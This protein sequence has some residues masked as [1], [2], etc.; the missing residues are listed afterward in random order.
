[1]VRKR[2]I[3]RLSEIAQNPAKTRA[4]SDSL[5]GVGKTPNRSTLRPLGFVDSDEHGA[6]LERSGNKDSLLVWY[7]HTA[8]LLRD[9]G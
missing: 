1:M 8:D 9:G 7:W 4:S 3:A 2:W 5:K 6:L